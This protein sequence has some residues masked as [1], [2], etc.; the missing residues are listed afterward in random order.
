MISIN[1]EKGVAKVRVVVQELESR[2]LAM[3]LQNSSSSQF[4]AVSAKTERVE[5]I[6]LD[7]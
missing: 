7:H 1:V 6:N 3:D 5:K 2:K 4:D